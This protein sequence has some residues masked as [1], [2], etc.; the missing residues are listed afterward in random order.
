M[1]VGFTIFLDDFQMSVWFFC[2][3]S[4]WKGL[5]LASVGRVKRVLQDTG[6]LN[7]DTVL[8]MNICSLFMEFGVKRMLEFVFF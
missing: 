5:S 3:F 1:L 6:V 7:R 4:M 8:R 2:L